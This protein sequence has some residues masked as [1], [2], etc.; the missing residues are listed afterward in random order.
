MLEFFGYHSVFCPLALDPYLYIHGWGQGVVQYYGDVREVGVC[1]KGV[2]Y[3]LGVL[4][5]RGGGGTCSKCT[6]RH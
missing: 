4:G 5:R 1:F 6:L 2:R 3:F